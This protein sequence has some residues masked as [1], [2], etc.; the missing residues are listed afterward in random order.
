MSF[1]VWLKAI[2]IP[3]FT[4]TIIPIALGSIIAWH[5]TGSF[6]WFKFL[7]AMLGAVLIH[8]GTNLAN[9]Y[10]DHLEGCDEA[11]LSPTPF[12]GGSR[13]IQ[14]GLIPAKKILFVSLCSF[15]IGASIGLYLNYISGKNIIL[16]LG[17]I[18]VFLGFFHNVKP[19][20]IYY[21]GWGELAVGIG[22]GPLMVLGSYYVQ[23]QRLPLQVFLISIPIG[24]LIAL[25]LFINEFPDYPADKIVGKKTLVVILGKRNAVVLYHILLVAVYLLIVT[26]VIFKFL[27]SISLIVLLTLPLAI[28]AF[29]V[30]KKNFDKIYELLPANAST[31]GLHSMIGVLLCIG[32]ILDK[33]L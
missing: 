19:L 18:G 10:F 28:K 24:I 3:F 14:D 27:P 4:A 20:R 30:S 13:V 23:A 5:D 25:V 17:I 2:R 7:L 15:I 8:M 6:V 16:L 1:K 11:N 12:S 32:I 29:R 9:D 21:G 31:I 26:F 22:F 33:I